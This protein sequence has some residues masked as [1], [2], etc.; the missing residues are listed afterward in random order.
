MYVTCNNE[1]VMW[2]QLYSVLLEDVI[3]VGYWIRHACA[4]FHVVLLSGCRIKNGTQFTLHVLYNLNCYEYV[5]YTTSFMLKKSSLLFWVPWRPHLRFSFLPVC[6]CNY[7]R[8]LRNLF[9]AQ[10]KHSVL[11]VSSNMHRESFLQ[12]NSHVP[13]QTTCTVC[14]LHTCCM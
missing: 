14:T 7:Y 9:R 11:L 13:R 2:F 6:L 4:D 5:K 8:G 10:N 12:H 3:V 1:S